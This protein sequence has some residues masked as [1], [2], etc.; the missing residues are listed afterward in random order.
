MGLRMHCHKHAIRH[1]CNRQRQ[2]SAG[3]GS[4]QACAGPVPLG[5]WVDTAWSIMLSM[6]SGKVCQ[7]KEGG[8][9]G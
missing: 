1:A 2:A 7:G 6:G 5:F 8:G 9:P 3:D 4:V